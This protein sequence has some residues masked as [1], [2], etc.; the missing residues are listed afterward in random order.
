MVAA[1][2]LKRIV[3]TILLIIFLIFIGQ[4]RIIS[5]IMVALKT[6]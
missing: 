3:K 5:I 4:E 6:S 1:S 2:R